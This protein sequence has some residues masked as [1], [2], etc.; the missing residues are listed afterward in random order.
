MHLLQIYG[1]KADRLT[2]SLAWQKASIQAALNLL[3]SI[4]ST[5]SRLMASHSKGAVTMANVYGRNKYEVRFN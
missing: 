5:T 4:Y 2:G 3:R 1:R